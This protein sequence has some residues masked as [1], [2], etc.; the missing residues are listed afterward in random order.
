M[1]ASTQAISDIEDAVRS[2]SLTKR[3]F[4]HDDYN[5]EDEDEDEEREE[6]VS[7]YGS[8]P[9]HY[10]QDLKAD[11]RPHLHLHRENKKL[12]HDLETARR[13]IAHLED[14]C[15]E[16]EGRYALLQ[17]A[18]MALSREVAVM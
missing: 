6:K 3:K 10:Q 2:Q 1:E 16:R 11:P 13:W 18:F 8:Q 17:R 7:D 14:Q 4:N 15:R 9:H 5:V 12:R